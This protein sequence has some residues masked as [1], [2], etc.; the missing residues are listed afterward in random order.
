M[1]MVDLCLWLPL[2]SPKPKLKLK[3]KQRMAPLVK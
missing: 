2:H 3:L 1:M